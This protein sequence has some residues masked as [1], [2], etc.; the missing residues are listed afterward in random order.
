MRDLYILSD[1]NH[2]NTHDFLT[3]D[4]REKHCG[5]I[6]KEHRDA[7]LGEYIM[8]L[9]NSDGY[10]NWRGIKLKRKVEL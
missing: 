4:R 9:N 5:M 1:K 8:L 10:Y 6:F 3:E 7:W 2:G